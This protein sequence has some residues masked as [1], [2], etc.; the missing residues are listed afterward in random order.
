MRPFERD[1][2]IVVTPR[3]IVSAAWT[4][5]LPHGR[6]VTADGEYAVV[7]LDDET[8]RRTL[9]ENI[10][11]EKSY[12]TPRPRIPLLPKRRMPP[13]D[14]AYEQPS[15][16]DQGRCEVRPRLRD[17]FCGAGGAA[18]GYHR[19]GWDV[20][21][22]DIEPQPNYPFE[23]IQADAFEVLLAGPDGFTAN[24][25]SPPCRDHTPL[26]ALHGFAGSG[27]ILAAIRA[28]LQ[29]QGLP[30]IIENVVGAEMVNPVK[31]C[32]SSFGLDVQRHR[33]FETSWPV[34]FPPEC[35]HGLNWKPIDV[36]GTGASRTGPRLD[37]RGGNSRKPRNLEHAREVLG[38]D[39]MTRRE[40]SQ[41]IPPAYTEWLGT[42]L[43][44]ALDMAA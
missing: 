24:H 23:F 17:L 31:L 22:Y 35:C 3:A 41:A 10:V 1:E 29:R 4:Y 9:M 40:L 6:Y 43:L 28:G 33:L 39:W 16:L 5:S 42:Q 18:M 27:W 8:T 30:Y 13:L 44:A 11:R 2:R 38:I 12:R 14:A 34:M 36:T 19:A 21:G 25:A 32:G 15:L 26:A 20:V 7:I 37:G